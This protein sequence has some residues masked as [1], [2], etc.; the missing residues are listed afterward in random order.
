MAL[1]GDRH[2]VET[3]VSKVVNSACDAGVVLV[4]ATGASLQSSGAALYARGVAELVSNPSGRVPVGVTLSSFVSIDQTRYHRNFQK[5]EQV[6]GEP[7]NLL[8]KGWVVTDSIVAGLTVIPGETAYLGVSGK[9]TNLNV[10]GYPKV[11]QFDSKPDADGF[12]KINV[13]LPIV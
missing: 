12:A 11:G 3:D 10:S 13:N 1:K 5:M 2:I 4:L 8:K 6:V 9:F 7:G